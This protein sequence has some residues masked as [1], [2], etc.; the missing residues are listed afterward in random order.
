MA[1]VQILDP[2][3]YVSCFCCWFSPCSECF[4]PG[5]SV[6]L[7]PQKSTFLNSNSIG[8]SKATG[9]S[10]LRLLCVTLVKQSLS[11]YFITF[12]SPQIFNHHCHIR[13]TLLQLSFRHLPRL[14][15]WH[16]LNCM[17]KILFLV[18]SCGDP[19]TPTNG[20]RYGDTF[21]YQSRVVLECDPQYRLV[22]DLIRT[23]QV[24]GA[25]SG[26]QPTCER[27]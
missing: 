6:F 4:S 19:G 22:G 15:W 24:D 10:V 7:P 9:L 1:R 23:C 5:S 8:N 27:K 17:Y 13:T 18:V 3:S 16:F 2:V 12:I 20:V 14:I 25:W 26:T 21:T 11:I